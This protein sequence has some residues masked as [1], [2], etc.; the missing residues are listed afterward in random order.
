M[1]CVGVISNLVIEIV[2]DLQGAGDLDGLLEADSAHFFSNL[3]AKLR[4]FSAG[5]SSKHVHLCLISLKQHAPE[6]MQKVILQ[7]MELIT[8]NIDSSMVYMDQ[9]KILFCLDML[10]TVT[11]F[12]K[13]RTLADKFPLPKKKSI[14]DDIVKEE[15]KTFDPDRQNKSL[16]NVLRRLIV[17]VQP[18]MTATTAPSLSFK[19]LQIFENLVPFL[20]NREMVP[21]QA[22]ETFS[23]EEGANVAIPC[24]LSAIAFELLPNFK[25][26]LQSGSAT[27]KFV[28]TQM[29]T[30]SGK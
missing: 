20:A 27:G 6:R 11:E 8:Q 28:P 30:G 22:A 24:A 9:E 15:P 18:Y 26:I 14:M 23:P 16:T 1:E 19:A 21:E 4:Y 25:A 17:R 5:M 12:I 2:I 7:L 3:F 29:Q 10:I 13:D